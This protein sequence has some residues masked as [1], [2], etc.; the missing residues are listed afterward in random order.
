ML[1]KSGACLLALTTTTFAR[2]PQPNAKPFADALSIISE[3]AVTSLNLTV[4]LGYGLYNGYHNT[5][6]NLN[7][8]RG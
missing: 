3:R 6:A 2:V 8:W 5:S 7:I 1:L 4:D